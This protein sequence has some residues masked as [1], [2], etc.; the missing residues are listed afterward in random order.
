MDER[1]L[2]R[3]LELAKKA[4]G[5][6][7]PNP[8]V[9][10]VIVENN[11]I[12]SEGYHTRAGLRHAEIIALENLS[13]L[14]SSDAVLYVTLE[15]C[16]TRG[17]TGSCVEAIIKAG[18]SRVVVGALDPNPVHA[19]RGLDELREAG[20]DVCKVEGPLAED[21]LNLN[22]IFNYQIVRKQPFFALK[23]AVTK[24]S[25]I[26]E[27]HGQ[28]SVITGEKARADVMRWRRLFPAIAI[29]AGTV[30]ADD[31]CLTSR[32]PGG[33]WCPRRIIL[34]G[35][36]SSV[37]ERGNLPK[38]YSDNFCENTLVVTDKA[39]SVDYIRRARLIEAGVT[40][41]ELRLDS[42][43]NYSYSKLR[44]I[45]AE[46]DLTGV[47][48][49]GGAKVAH[50]ILREK[51]VDYLF[52]YQSPKTFPNA[53]AVEVPSLADFPLPEKVQS[54]KLGEDLL[55]RGFLNFSN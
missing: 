27:H 42:G 53:D 51:A 12:V 29:G 32:L 15:P 21:C 9:G 52:W 23:L 28:S 55:I 19:G 18:F 25:K 3:A 22:L 31:P 35:K 13:R 37:P 10:A 47:Y 20:I 48:F 34:D 49:E 40:I 41:R 4:W 54:T 24:D 45:L 44:E 36:L 17:Q 33:E 43:G 14:P 46:E 5:E 50:Q 7:H 38:V 6:T 39:S 30:I 2:G 26:A 16:S 1:Y 8:M 11:E